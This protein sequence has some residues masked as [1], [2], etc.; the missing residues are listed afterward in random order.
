MDSKASS[1]AFN[2]H[3]FGNHNGVAEILIS[4]PAY[5]LFY[6][7]VPASL[8][9]V[10]QALNLLTTTFGAM[11]A[12]VLNSVF[13]RWLPDD[14]DDGHAER[15]YVFLAALCALNLVA[16]A[17]VVARGYGGRGYQYRSAAHAAAASSGSADDGAKRAEAY[18]EGARATDAGAP[19]LEE[20]APLLARA[21]A[22][23]VTEPEGA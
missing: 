2:V 16:F 22:A 5:D 12:A 20:S 21:T 23:D 15:M 6:S 4:I 3:V 1:D 18:G 19:A 8:K 10:C 9:S 11:V 13:A 7:E 14:L 17:R